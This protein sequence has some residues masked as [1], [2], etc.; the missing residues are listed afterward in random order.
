LRLR[1]GRPATLKIILGV[2]KLMSEEYGDRFEQPYSPTVGKI[3]ISPT[4]GF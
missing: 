1:D 2:D 4:T 3:V